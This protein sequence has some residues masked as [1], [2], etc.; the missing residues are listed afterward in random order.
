MKQRHG[1]AMVGIPLLVISVTINVLQAERIRGLAD[2]EPIATKALGRTVSSLNGQ[3]ATGEQVTIPLNN[4]L[5][6]ALYHFSTSCAWCQS[7]WE[8]IR[9]LAKNSGGR[10][11]VLAVSMEPPSVANSLPDLEGVS[12]MFGIDPAMISQ[13]A[14]GGTPHTLVVDG[15]GLVIY[16]WPGAYTDRLGRHVQEVFGVVLPGLSR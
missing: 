3:D 8:N 13:L 16:D 1:L 4:G 11:R 10:Y 15:D 7:N 5:P 14:L 6:T 9:A 2:L 12:V